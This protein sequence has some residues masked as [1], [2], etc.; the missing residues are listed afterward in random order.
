M[1]KDDKRKGRRMIDLR[2][3]ELSAEEYLFL[4]APKAP[5]DEDVRRANL[6]D[7]IKAKLKNAPPMPTDERME[8]VAEEDAKR[9]WEERTATPAK[10]PAQKKAPTADDMPILDVPSMMGKDMGEK[11]RESGFKEPERTKN[12]NKEGKDAKK[13]KRTRTALSNDYND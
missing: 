3:T 10:K 12:F 13:K 8:E 4:K 11:K 5:E 1:A 6:T 9:R 7:K 2:G